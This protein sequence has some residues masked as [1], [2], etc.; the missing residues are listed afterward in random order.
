[1]NPKKEE[2]KLEH[3]NPLKTKFWTAGRAVQ[4]PDLLR[5]CCGRSP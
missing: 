4:P 1:M 5:R 3:K 2:N